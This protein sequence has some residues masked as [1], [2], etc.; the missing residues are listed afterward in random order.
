[1]DLQA[2]QERRLRR[3]GVEPETRKYTPHVTLA[4]LRGVAPGGG[5]RLSRRPRRASGG[6]VHRRALRAL[7]GPR[8]DGRGTLCR[9]GRLSAGL[10]VRAT[11]SKP[12]ATEIK[13]L[14]N[15]IQIRRN[16]IK[17][18][19]NK[20]KMRFPGRR[21][22]LFND[23]KRCDLFEPG[24]RMASAAANGRAPWIATSLRS[25]DDNPAI[26]SNS[27]RSRPPPSSPVPQ[28]GSDD[29]GQHSIAF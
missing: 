13:I 12:S 15:E 5:R 1:M 16:K 29:S 6:G 3:I 24:S 27:T 7:F 18:R 19:R 23:L 14:R 2:E 8:R 21:L 20:I 25:C 22:E 28:A 26:M 17:G 4:R 11:K 10:G 9:R